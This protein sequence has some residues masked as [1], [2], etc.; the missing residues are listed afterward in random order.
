MNKSIKISVATYRRLE[1]AARLEETADTVINRAL[2]AL[3]QRSTPPPEP[4]ENEPER[5]WQPPPSNLPNLKHTKVL[6]A[7]IGNN[8][9][10]SP[11]WNEL[12][13]EMLIEANARGY[14]PAQLQGL[15][16]NLVSGKKLD[17]GYSPIPEIGVSMQ[18]LSAT[19]SGMVLVALARKASIRLQID[20]VWRNKRGAA[21]PGKYARI[22]FPRR[23]S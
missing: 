15:G 12:V 14:P 18:G 7:S 8:M 17:E 1:K 20:L 5:V 16:V 3:E 21:H 11:R 23:P 9:F 6:K 13:R 4:E 19:N 10:E 2:D 22:S